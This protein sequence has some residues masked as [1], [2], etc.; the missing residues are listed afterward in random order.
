LIQNY[1]YQHDYKLFP[2]LCPSWDN[3]ARFN[4]KAWIMFN[5]SPDKFKEWLMFHKKNYKPYSSEENFIFINAWNE[6]A[7]GNHLEPCRKWGKSYLEV[8][9]EVFS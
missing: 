8:V 2:G 7:E 4:N 5:S 6:W 1:Q 3:T 9:R